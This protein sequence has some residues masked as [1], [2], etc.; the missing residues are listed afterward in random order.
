MLLPPGRDGQCGNVRMLGR[1]NPWRCHLG[2][3]LKRI[4]MPDTFMHEDSDGQL[5]G[6]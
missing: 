2:S 3:E 4:P 1:V 6:H 5:C